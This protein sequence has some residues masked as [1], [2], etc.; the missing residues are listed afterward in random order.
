MKT[1]DSDTALLNSLELN[2]LELVVLSVMPNTWH[3]EHS[4]MGCHCE[5]GCRN[6]YPRTTCKSVENKQAEQ[7]AI[8]PSLEAVPHE[9]K[10]HERRF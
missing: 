7:D 9:S 8:R 3:F 4:S 1:S 2:D 10:K 5:I 6:G